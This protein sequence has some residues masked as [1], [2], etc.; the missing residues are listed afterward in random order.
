M[1]TATLTADTRMKL[2]NLGIICQHPEEG[3]YYIVQIPIPFKTVFSELSFTKNRIPEYYENKFYIEYLGFTSHQAFFIFNN[4][5]VFNPTG[6]VNSFTLLIEAKNH[7]QRCSNFEP[8]NLQSRWH[9]SEMGGASSGQFIDCEKFGLTRD[10]IQDI[11]ALLK[12]TKEDK[13]EMDKYL[14]SFKGAKKVEDL[15]VVDFVIEIIDRRFTKLFT[16]ERD[17]R[18]FLEGLQ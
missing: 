3:F 1:Y 17:A 7:I 10:I 14:D 16:F 15:L 12:K 11:D 9:V 13:K 4:Y 8:L 6:L 18:T 5:T 2:I